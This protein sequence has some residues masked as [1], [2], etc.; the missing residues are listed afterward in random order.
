MSVRVNL[1]LIHDYFRDSLV[2]RDVE[3][4][5]PFLPRVGEAVN[6]WIWIEAKEIKLVDVKNSYPKKGKK[7]LK[8]E[9]LTKT[10]TINDW[11]Y[12]VSIGCDRVFDVSFYKNDK[13]IPAEIYV[14][15][16]LN[17]DGI[18]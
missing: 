14:N 7:H 4:T 11:L 5:C 12:E 10:F 9:K 17:Q 15:L 13:I 2:V 3:W 6:P 16:Y 8:K 1:T 18:L